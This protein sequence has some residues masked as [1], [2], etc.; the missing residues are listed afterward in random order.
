MGVEDMTQSIKYGGTD[1]LLFTKLG[2]SSNN[3]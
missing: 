2:T 3:L 1:Y